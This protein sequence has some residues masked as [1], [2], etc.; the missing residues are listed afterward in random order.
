MANS[1]DQE[2]ACGNDTNDGCNSTEA[3]NTSISNKRPLASMAA[4]AESPSHQQQDHAGQDTNDNG[5]NGN[6]NGNDGNGNCNDGTGAPMT[7]K[8][9][10]GESIKEKSN[11]PANK[12]IFGSSTTSGFV[13]FGSSNADA[14]ITHANGNANNNCSSTG[15]GSKT[16][17]DSIFG[18]AT[19]TA[20]SGFGLGQSTASTTSGFGITSSTPGIFGSTSASTAKPISMFATKIVTDTTA[21]ETDMPTITNNGDGEGL[22]NARITSL[23]KAAASVPA[24]YT[25]IISLPLVEDEELIKNGEENEET[26]ITVR[27]KLFKLTKVKEAVV[28]VPSRLPTVEKTV[29]IQMATKVGQQPLSSQKE[30][31]EKDQHQ[32]EGG[33]TAT[34]A[35]A[36][37]REK[38]PSTTVAAKMDWKE[39]GIGPLRVLTDDKHARIV[40]RRENTPGG[41]GTKLILN[42]A[43]RDE[44]RVERMGDKFVKL[45]AFEVVDDDADHD[46]HDD[47]CK[48]GNVDGGDCNGKECDEKDGDGQHGNAV[49]FVSVQY[50]FKVKTLAEA[51][52]MVEA[53]DRYCGGSGTN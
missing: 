35:T 26:I 12:S 53:L 48:D 13:A 16:T 18:S 22:G 50:L 33:G 51:D 36:P 28:E 25:P 30:M 24:V 43:L 47:H 15:F 40:Q 34:N 11:K 46:D 2:D 17:T 32:A 45:A 1:A 39:V 49:K 7:K 42:L 29:G 9:K 8:A 31:E 21:S 27:A 41:Q 6:G 19:S 44:C 38:G 5:G 20:A 14:N 10:T 37:S 3:I 52:S 23:A 4:S